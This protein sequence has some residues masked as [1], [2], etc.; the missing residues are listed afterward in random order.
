MSVNLVG[1]LVPL[2]ILAIVVVIAV[3]YANTWSAKRAELRRRQAIGKEP[4]ETHAHL[5]VRITVG[6]VLLAA[7]GLFFILSLSRR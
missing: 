3:R 7:G 4:N 2:A 6:V 5:I 1:L